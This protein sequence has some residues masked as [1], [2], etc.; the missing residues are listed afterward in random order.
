[1]NE[2]GEKEKAIDLAMLQIERQHGKGAIMRFNS[3]QVVPVEAI[4]TGSIALDIA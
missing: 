1:M 2:E 3:D 4:P